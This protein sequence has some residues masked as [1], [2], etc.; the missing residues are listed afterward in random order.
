M[1]SKVV[2]VDVGGTFIDVVS[3]DGDTGDVAVE[4]QPVDAGPPRARA[5]DRTRATAR[6]AIGDRAL[7]PRIHR[8]DQ[9]ARAAPGREGR[10]HHDRGVPRRARA[11]TGEP[12]PHLRLGLGAAR[13]ARASR[14]SS[15]GHRAARTTRRGDRAARPRGPRPRGRRPRRAGAQRPSPSASCTRT[16]TRSTN[17]RPRRRSNDSTRISR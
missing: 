1:G 4:K 16:R 3:I 14:P 5:A 6:R 13:A 10:T 17:G 11:R 15:R 8:G 2:A 9:R 7:P 12:A